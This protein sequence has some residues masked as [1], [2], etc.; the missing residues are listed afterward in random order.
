MGVPL[1]VTCCFS[2]V[3]F[4]IFSLSLIFPIWLI[5]VLACSN[6]IYPAWDSLC[7]LDLGDCFL[8]HVREFFRYY[9]FKYFLRSFLLSFPSGTPTLWMLMCLMLS[10]RSIRLSWFRFSIFFLFCSM[11]V[12]STILSFRSLICSSAS[13]ILLSISPYVFF[14]S[15]ILLFISVCLFF[16]S[17][18]SL[19]NISC[20]F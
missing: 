1:Y 17:S 12:I 2:L 18:R 10:Q 3:A 8:S 7:F 4:R 20:I 9:H 13:V 14:I 16:S 19:L 5:C 6:W 15:V 11:A